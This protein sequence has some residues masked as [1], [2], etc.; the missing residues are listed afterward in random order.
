MI[1]R[2]EGRVAEPIVHNSIFEISCLNACC[3]ITMES[4][5]KVLPVESPSLEAP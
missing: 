2:G 5:L 3:D 1:D 4:P